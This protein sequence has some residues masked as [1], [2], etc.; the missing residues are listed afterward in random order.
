MLGNGCDFED[1]DVGQDDNSIDDG[2]DGDIYRYST[3]WLPTKFFLQSGH[4]S[5]RL[6]TSNSARLENLAIYHVS[7]I[8]VQKC[9][10]PEISKGGLIKRTT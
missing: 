10:G 3:Q 8:K 6:R 7:C 4:E 5:S 2:Q 1:I 9:R